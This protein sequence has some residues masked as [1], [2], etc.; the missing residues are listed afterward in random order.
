M[1]PELQS[2]AALAIVLASALWLVHRAWQRLAQASARPGCGGGCGCGASGNQKI[3][4][5]L[6][7]IG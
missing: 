5:K 7:D 2:F 6:P 3:P 1:N 4:G